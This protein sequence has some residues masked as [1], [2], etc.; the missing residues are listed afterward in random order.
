MPS[1][2]FAVAAD[3]GA[4]MPP[5][6]MQYSPHLPNGS[7]PIE[8]IGEDDDD[9]VPSEYASPSAVEDMEYHS[10]FPHSENP[11]PAFRT[12][13]FGDEYAGEYGDIQEDGA[14]AGALDGHGGQEQY[15]EAY[16]RPPMDDEY[17]EYDGDPMHGAAQAYND[18]RISAPM[19]D[20]V[21]EEYDEQYEVDSPPGPNHH[22]PG[23]AILPTDAM[24]VQVDPNGNAVEYEM[25]QAP[26]YG[27]QWWEIHWAET[28]EMRPT[29]MCHSVGSTE[30]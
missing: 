29:S 30:A 14:D 20:M 21:P 19:H 2:Q 25:G 16:Q 1:P 4:A 6:G 8:V 3:H 10:E 11:G 24:Q 15:D 7:Y 26:I 12:N 17:V 27:N 13:S 5:P 22:A 23:E 28:V 9:D 18:D